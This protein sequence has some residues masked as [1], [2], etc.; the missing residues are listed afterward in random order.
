MFNL[1]GKRGGGTELGCPVCKMSLRPTELESHL[2]NEVEQL[3]C[4]SRL[5]RSQSIRLDEPSSSSQGSP[6]GI[7]T[8]PNNKK[9]NPAESSQDSRWEVR[10]YILILFRMSHIYVLARAGFLCSK[11]NHI[12]LAF[13]GETLPDDAFNV[14]ILSF[15]ACWLI[16]NSIVLP[17]VDVPPREGKSKFTTSHQN[18]KKTRREWWSPRHM[19]CVPNSVTGIQRAIVCSCGNLSKKGES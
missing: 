5:A 15:R 12:L 14:E 9:E 13:V 8:N 7:S 1:T 10:P 6:S 19:S 2:L 11:C 17:F 4:M 18:T 16:F 3:M